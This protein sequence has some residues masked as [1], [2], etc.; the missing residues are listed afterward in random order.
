VIVGVVVLVGVIVGVVVLV[1][2]IVGVVVL[3]GVI[4]GVGVGVPVVPT[5]GNTPK[6]TISTEFT[7]AVEYVPS[8]NQIFFISFGSNST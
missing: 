7:N 2:V 1:G 6:S 4:V 3:V 5:G 8:I